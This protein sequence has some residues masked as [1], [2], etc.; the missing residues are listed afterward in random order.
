MANHLRNIQSLGIPLIS[1][2]PAL[3]YGLKTLIQYVEKI[4]YEEIRETFWR[5]A[6]TARECDVSLLKVIFGDN[7]L[8][9][10]KI[11]HKRLV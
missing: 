9:E 7:I 8:I 11:Y 3:R 2:G 5:I 6:F 10:E 1:G 4:G